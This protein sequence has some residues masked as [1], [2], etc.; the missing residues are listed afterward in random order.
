MIPKANIA[1]WRARA[2]WQADAQVEQD[3]I[4]SRAIAELF[5]HPELA[6]S[7]VFRGGTALYKIYLTPPAR[8]SEDI[9]LVQVREEPIG[10]TL[11]RARS[12][13]DPWLG[14]PRRQLREGRVNLVYRFESEDVPPLKL[15]LKI[16]INT[17]E[18]FTVLGVARA[19]F[20]VTNPWFGG[21][22]EVSIYA[23]DELLATKL[24][25]LYQRKKGRDLFDLWYALE[26]GLVDPTSL[27]ACFSR[28]M[29]R[30]GRSVTRA[31]FEA[32]LAGK[33]AQPDFRDDVPPL[34][35]SGL[36]WDFDTAMDIVLERLVALLPGDPWK[37]ED[38]RHTD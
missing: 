36:S 5:G 15:R 30:E 28:Y 7:L 35:R 6:G 29:A 14:E 8:Y 23:P 26:E 20:E 24:R 37:G 13:L 11:D 21:R 25:A 18:H 1:A 22:A 12:V 9:D 33:R 2:P 32:N 10:E 34:L 19:P 38:T 31:Q 27:V 3:L 17:R 4:V 16:E